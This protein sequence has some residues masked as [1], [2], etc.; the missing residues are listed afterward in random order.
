MVR[1]VRLQ[2]SRAAGFNLKTLSQQ[3]NSRPDRERV[4]GDTFGW[5]KS[6]KKTDRFPPNLIRLLPDSLGTTTATEIEPQLSLHANWLQV[7]VRVLLS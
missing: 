7:S 5:A 1:P 2:L 3:A 4:L 6:G